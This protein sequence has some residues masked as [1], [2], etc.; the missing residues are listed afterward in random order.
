[1]L[2]FRGGAHLEQAVA[3]TSFSSL[4]HGV[5]DGA[6]AADR[7]RLRRERPARGAKAGVIH[8]LLQGVVLPAEDV[9]G[10]LSVSGAGLVSARSEVGAGWLNDTYLRC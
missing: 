3:L 1:M 2:A 4:G 8:G 7:V 10:M 6:R 5:L 9:V